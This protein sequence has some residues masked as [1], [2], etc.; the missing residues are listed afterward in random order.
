MFRRYLAG[1]AGLLC[2]VALIAAGCGGKPSGASPQRVA[3]DYIKTL[4]A[5]QH[6]IIVGDKVWRTIKSGDFTI[7]VVRVHF[8]AYELAALGVYSGP[9]VDGW[10]TIYVH[11]VHSDY[12]VVG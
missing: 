9:M 6:V 1:A 7:V 2:V 10:T 5:N 12:A 4:A 8:R 11:L 3:G